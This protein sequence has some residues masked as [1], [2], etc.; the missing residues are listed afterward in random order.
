MSSRSRASKEKP[1]LKADPERSAFAPRDFV[2]QAKSPE[3]PSAKTDSPADL[4]GA[5]HEQRR[6]H[7]RATTDTESQTPADPESAHPKQLVSQAEVGSR[8][9]LF[10]AYLRQREAPR[11]AEPIS[12]LSEGEKASIAVASPETTQAKTVQAKTHTA[13]VIQR[14]L[15]ADIITL[16]D[17]QP[18]GTY[19]QFIAAI[20]ASNPAQRL[21]V[22]KDKTLMNAIGTDF[23]KAHS[24]AIVG[25]LQEGS[26]KWRAPGQNAFYNELYMKIE[27]GMNNRGLNT[28]LNVERLRATMNC[29]ESV[30]FSLFLLGRLTEQKIYNLLYQ[31]L[32]LVGKLDN[33]SVWS[34]LGYHTTEPLQD[35]ANPAAGKLVYYLPQNAEGRLTQSYPDHVAISLGGGNVASLWDQPDNLGFAQV[36]PARQFGARFRIYLGDSPF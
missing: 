5:Y 33:T 22:L 29:W 28:I 20:G 3:V 25:A 8:S 15:K 36:I 21:Q 9:D 30:L 11:S 34:K 1:S 14:V 7:A 18:H 4:L 32:E 16:L 23:S 24:L 26:F 27:V 10:D 13:G 35:N 6:A 31:G 17:G 12:V 2:A 19:D